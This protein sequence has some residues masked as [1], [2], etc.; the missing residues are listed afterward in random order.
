MTTLTNKDTGLTITYDGP[1]PIKSGWGSWEL[2]PEFRN[3]MY[4][5][6]DIDAWV[7]SDVTHPKDVYVLSEDKK[8][9]TL[10]GSGTPVFHKSVTDRFKEG[11][12]Q[13][14]LEEGKV[15]YGLD[16]DGDQ[17]I[18][19]VVDGEVMAVLENGAFHHYDEPWSLTDL[20]VVP[21]PLEPRM[22]SF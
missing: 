12:H 13:V 1:A 10:G 21:N 18:G 15:Y 19:T 5:E 20:E 22:G 4:S 3:G 9:I 6:L 8:T 17:F 11:P 2:P 7:V 16:F 14:E